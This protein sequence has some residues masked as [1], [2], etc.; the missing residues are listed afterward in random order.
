MTSL[1]MNPTVDAAAE[2]PAAATA[3]LRMAAGTP[4]RAEVLTQWNRNLEAGPAR[5]LSKV[6]RATGHT[7]GYGGPSFTTGD[8]RGGTRH[9]PAD[10]DMDPEEEDLQGDAPVAMDDAGS[11]G[12]AQSD[13][14]EDAAVVDLRSFH[15]GQE[16][17]AAVEA[18]VRDVQ[19]QLPRNSR[20][21]GRAPHGSQGAA[22]RA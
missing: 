6:A 7:S 18:A 4:A 17:Q 22:G 16:A 8:A 19:P 12:T 20:R 21:Q 14:E 1:W 5:G 13:V 10:L 15:H 2:R 3:G 9:L 11:W